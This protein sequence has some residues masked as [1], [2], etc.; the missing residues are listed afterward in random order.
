[1]SIL[2]PY[3]IHY[4]LTAD[5]QW[6]SYCLAASSADEAIKLF[7]IGVSNG[8]VVVNNRCEE[9]VE[10]KAYLLSSLTPKFWVV[11]FKRKAS[12][13]W[14]FK[15]KE[16]PIQKITVAGYTEVEAIERFYSPN[17]KIWKKLKPHNVEVLEV[18][19]LT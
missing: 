9:M 5:A 3:Q 13:N 6:H 4:R 2:E 19:T 8:H 14:K 11:K 15:L 1:M 12:A 18:T 7:K 10:V 16:T 17:Q